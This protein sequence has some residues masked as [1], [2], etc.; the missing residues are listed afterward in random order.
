MGEIQNL[1]KQIGFNNWTYYFKKESYPK[2]FNGFIGQLH[3]YKII[4]D[5][6]LTLEKAE[7][8]KKIK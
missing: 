6:Y 5:S 8:D 3:F 7:E 4:K 1:S 2:S